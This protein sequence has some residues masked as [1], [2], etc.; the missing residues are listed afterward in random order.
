MRR[1]ARFSFVAI[2]LSVTAVLVDHRPAQAQE[3][4]VGTIGP[5]TLTSREG[6]TLCATNLEAHGS[7]RVGLALL[8]AFNTREPL[9]LEYVDLSL[10]AG[11]CH[12]FRPPRD[13]HTIVVRT[14][15][16]R[17]A[18]DPEQ[19]IAL[20]VQK[21]SANGNVDAADYVVWRKSFG[22]EPTAPV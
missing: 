6:L 4:M 22:T 2:A 1:Y 13:H 9:R 8:D 12:S 20:S 16:I 14:G 7:R 11:A 5:L 15:Y 10:G 18:T 17:A 3:C 21:T 19:A